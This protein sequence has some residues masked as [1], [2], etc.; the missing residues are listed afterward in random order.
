MATA[1]EDILWRAVEWVGWAVSAA[2]MTAGG[3]IWKSLQR[4]RKHL[5]DVKRKMD[6]IEQAHHEFVRHDLPGRLRRAEQ[7]IDDAAS[8]QQRMIADLAVVKN[9]VKWICAEMGKH[10]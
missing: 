3:W 9:D 5:Q 4:D 6:V 8:L 7:K 1:P 10:E 2:A